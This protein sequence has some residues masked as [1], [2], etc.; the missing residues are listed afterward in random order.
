MDK[1]EEDIK[2]LVELKGH[3]VNFG[4]LKCKKW[5]DSHNQSCKDCPTELG[6]AIDVSAKLALLDSNSV[7]NL[8]EVLNSKTV[9]EVISISFNFREGPM[10]IP[11]DQEYIDEFLY[12]E[13]KED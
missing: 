3:K 6:C 8:E 7:E 11:P 4:T 10:D 12:P 2:Y 9:K 5:L 1:V 13:E